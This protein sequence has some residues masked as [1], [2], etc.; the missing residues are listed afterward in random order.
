MIDLKGLESA[1]ARSRAARRWAAARAGGRGQR[2]NPRAHAPHCP[3]DRRG[4]AAVVDF[5]HYI[6]QQSGARN[7]R[8]RGAA[9]GGHAAAMPGSPPSTPAARAFCAGTSIS[10]ATSASFTIYDADDQMNVIKQLCKVD[11]PGRKAHFPRA[12]S[13]PRFRTRKTACSPPPSGLKESGEDFRA[14]TISE[15]YAAYERQLNSQQRA[16]FRRLLI[17]KTLDAVFRASAGAGGLP[18]QVFATSWW[19]NTRIRTWRNTCWCG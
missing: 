12:R 11:E 6:H 1:A 4:R 5:G 8:A 10:W 7:A 13:A 3:A 17:L 16:G 19:T 18:A 15:V 2:Q 9:G 14:K